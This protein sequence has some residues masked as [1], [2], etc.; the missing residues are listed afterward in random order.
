MW[1]DY[2]SGD[3]IKADVTQTA[4]SLQPGQYRVLSDKRLKAPYMTA[5]ERAETGPFS[6]FEL[7]ANFPNPFNHRTTIVF[8]MP[9]AGDVTI[10][11]INIHG[12]HVR[13]LNAGALPAGRRML[14]WNGQ[15]DN[16][17]L[18]AGGLYFL[19][20]YSETQ[21]LIRKMLFVP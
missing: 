18:V 16:G 11:I 19:R 4:L 3:S 10:D 9:K 14:A 8:E 13:T 7:F 20:L 2:F 6:D 21:I 12:Q 17:T 5:V 1:Y 15:T